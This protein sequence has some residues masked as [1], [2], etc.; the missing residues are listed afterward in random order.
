MPGVQAGCDEDGVL[1]KQFGAST[2]GH[3]LLYHADGRLLFSGGITNARGHAG[4]SAGLE[5]ILS[6]LNRGTA[7]QADAPVFGCP[8]YGPLPVAREGDEPWRK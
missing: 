5:A 1:A 3:V 4:S 6:L 7:E 2:S 8:L